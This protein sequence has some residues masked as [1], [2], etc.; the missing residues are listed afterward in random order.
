[1]SEY[2]KEALEEANAHWLKIVRA[3]ELAWLIEERKLVARKQ[4]VLQYVEDVVNTSLSFFEQTSQATTDI[5]RLWRGHRSRSQKLP[6][7]EP[8]PAPKKVKS[9]PRFPPPKVI[10]RPRF[11]QAT[12]RRVWS[13]KDFRPANNK[14]IHTTDFG[15]FEYDIW[16]YTDRPPAGNEQGMRLNKVRAVARNDREVQALTGDKHAWVGL[17]IGIES[18]EERRLLLKKAEP[19]NVTQLKA[20]SP[21]NAPVVN[22]DKFDAAS[23]EEKQKRKAQIARNNERNASSKSSSGSGTESSGQ[24]SETSDEDSADEMENSN[25][26]SPGKPTK[27]KRM[28]EKNLVKKL[29]KFGYDPATMDPFEA[30]G[31]ARLGTFS[32]DVNTGRRIKHKG[33]NRWVGANDA[34]FEVQYD[35]PP[36]AAAALEE[37]NSDSDGGEKAN[38]VAELGE[39]SLTRVRPT[40]FYH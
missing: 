30:R 7:V 5:Q 10:P 37:P 9:K 14:W 18:Y 27:H 3:K 36:Q 19:E 24:E 33:N 39:G 12:L 40:V 15:H 11:S 26:K 32:Y 25:E 29:E 6:P 35:L 2:W 31:L 17:P 21:Y 23:K 8:A 1:M 13:R 16:E 20:K 34:S 28:N 38:L 4:F 22:W